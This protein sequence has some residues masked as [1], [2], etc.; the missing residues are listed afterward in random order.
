VKAFQDN[1][2]L[3]ALKKKTLGMI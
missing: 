1:K 3:K 2:Q